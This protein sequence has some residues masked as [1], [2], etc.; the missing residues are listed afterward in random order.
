MSTSGS[1]IKKRLTSHLITEW[2]PTKNGKLTPKDVLPGSGKRVWWLCNRGHEWQAIIYGRSRGSGCPYCSGHKVCK[3][4]CLATVNQKLSKEWHPTKNSKLTP[5]DVTPY[6]HKKIWWKCSKGH[7]WQ[8]GVANRSSGTGCPYC[9]GRK[10]CK[11]NCLATINT[12]FAK[13]W[14][15][16]KNGNLT[17]K[18]V[19]V[20]SEKKVW[21][22]CSKKHIWLQRIR[23][24]S[25][26]IE[27]LLCHKASIEKDEK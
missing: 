22:R 20:R 13:Q 8:I 27:C 7:I 10:I 11:D 23:Y 5:N 21:W 16:T 9:A 18:D 25:I 12:E 26:N 14:H 4:N 24:R 17:P 15:P 2:H 6:S 19:S 3:D 1:K